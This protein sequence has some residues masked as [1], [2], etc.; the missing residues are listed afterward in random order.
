VLTVEGA[1]LRT[2]GGST[3]GSLRDVVGLPAGEVAE[4]AFVAETAGDWTMTRRALDGSL[5]LRA[6]LRVV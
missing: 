6:I 3:P 1:A 4:V 2:V 5:D